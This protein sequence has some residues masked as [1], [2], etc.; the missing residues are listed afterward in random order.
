[1]FFWTSCTSVV[2]LANAGLD[3]ATMAVHELA[4]L[5]AARSVGVPARFGLGVRLLGIVVHTDLRGIWA[6]APRQRRRVYL[7]G[8][9]A[10]AVVVSTAVLV[11]AAV[12]PP[13]RGALV[14]L[15][16]VRIIG[17]LWQCQ[18]YTRTDMYCVMTD[19]VGARNLHEDAS[20][21]AIAQLR[22]VADRV[23]D[24][25]GRQPSTRVDPL[26]G[27]GDREQ[28]VIRRY[29]LWML[30]GST[31]WL[32]AYCWFVIPIDI[33]V[34]VRGFH[35]VHD[36]SLVDGIITL[37]LVGIP[38]VVLLYLIAVRGTR[39]VSRLRARLADTAQNMSDD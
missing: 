15:V 13:V 9:A 39:R 6:V 33:G 8:L 3:Y 1:M 19:L 22:R 5:A 27:V 38:Q 21:Y 31:V 11:A 18:I 24:R 2:L 4:H 28:V 35:A 34:F 30:A 37:A 16:L 25:V 23:S 36:G 20:V 14:A 29:A 26:V 12:G 10:D 32:A 17:M 7:A